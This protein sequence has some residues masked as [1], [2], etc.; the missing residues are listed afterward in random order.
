MYNSTTI[1]MTD[2]SLTESVGAKVTEDRKKQIRVAAALNDMVMSDYV[3]EAIEEKVDR[4][5]ESGKLHS[6]MVSM[7]DE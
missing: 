2:E 4:D 7:T 1:I 5:I 3:R 6:R